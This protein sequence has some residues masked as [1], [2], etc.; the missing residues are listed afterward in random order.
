MSV[1]VGVVLTVHVDPDWYMEVSCQP[2]Q[3]SVTYREAGSAFT[4]A[5]NFSSIEEM[6]AVANAMLLASD[7]FRK[8]V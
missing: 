7:T 3:L 8:A 6:R 5:V 2:E 1:E 4:A